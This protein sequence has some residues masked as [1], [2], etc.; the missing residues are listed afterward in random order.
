V[1]NSLEILYPPISS[2]KPSPH[3][4]RKH[5]R[6]QRRKLKA[7]LTKFGQVTPIIVDE[8][9]VILDGHAVYETLLELGNEE[10][11][12]IVVH[13]RNEAEI[14]ALRLALNRVGQEAKWDHAK[15]KAEFEALLNLGF[16]LEFTAFEAVEIDMTLSIDTPA[17]GKV[18]KVATASAEGKAEAEAEAEAEATVTRPGDVWCLGRHIVACGDPNDAE[19]LRILLGEARA[20]VVFTTTPYRSETSREE[21]VA[22]LT[23]FMAALKPA[24]AD[25]AILFLHAKWQDA[26]ELL[27]AA[28]QEKLEFQNLCVWVKSHAEPANIYKSQHRLVFVFKFGEANDANDLKPGKPGPGRSDVWNCASAKGSDRYQPEHSGEHPVFIVPMIADALEDVSRRG[29]IVLDPYLAAGPS[30]IAAEQ[31][32]RICV[33]IELDPVRVDVAVRW[34]QRETG[35]RAVNV[36]TG[37]TFAAIA[38]RMVMTRMAITAAMKPDESPT[39]AICDNRAGDR[40]V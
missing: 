24:L 35:K 20:S 8:S 39:P 4:A 32:G 11:A 3:A 5:N 13:N 18:A 29:D 14:R 10:I 19:L 27:E 30:L 34:W 26:R 28:M 25:G 33:G 17:G 21:F 38:E 40:N 2:V 7:L 1:K 6:R 36:E 23:T 22:F 15:L 9:Y 12:V 37:E 31:V 16:D